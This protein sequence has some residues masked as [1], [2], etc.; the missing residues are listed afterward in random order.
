MHWEKTKARRREENRGRNIFG[1]RKS[2]TDTGQSTP[3]SGQRVFSC[4]PVSQLIATASY[5]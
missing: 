5:A 3:T 1:R 4:G 2:S